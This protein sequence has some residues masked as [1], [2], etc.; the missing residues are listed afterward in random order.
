[1]ALMAKATSFLLKILQN[2]LSSIEF[3]CSLTKNARSVLDEEGGGSSY[4]D[5][6]VPRSCSLSIYDLEHESNQNSP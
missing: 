6:E 3:V 2:S 5:R 1:M 4:T